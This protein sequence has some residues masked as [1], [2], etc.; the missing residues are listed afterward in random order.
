MMNNLSNNGIIDNTSIYLSIST[1]EKT[2]LF[3]LILS[4]LLFIVLLIGLIGNILVIYVVLNY[5]LLKTVTNI[6]LLHLA[7]SDV[8]FLSGVPFFIS[9]IITHSW[10]FGSFACKIFFLTQGVNQYTSIIILSLLSFDRYL[11]VCHVAKSIAWRSRFNP[12]ILIISIWILSFILMLPIISFTTLEE[13]FESVVQCTIIL[14]LF[15]SRTPYFVYVAYT[16]SI[17]FFV[18]L[19]L[20]TYF[21]IRIVYRLRNQLPRQHSRSRLSMRARRKVTILVL[22]VIS[23]HIICCTPYWTFQMFAT[24]ELLPQTSS[25]LIPMSSLTQFLLFVNSST[26]P[27]LYA[28]IRE[29]FLASFKRAFHCCLKTNNNHIIQH[30]DLD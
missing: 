22:T 27:I 30:K 16:S 10:L 14:P 24:S 29:I 18:P 12:N 21:H 3:I 15:Q 11:A 26:N 8:I 23:V 13:T 4:I 25:I 6:Y 9:S 5:G 28:F 7:L 20:M 17:T 1:I 19:T 2:S